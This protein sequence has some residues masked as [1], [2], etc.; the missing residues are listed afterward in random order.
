MARNRN[1]GGKNEGTGRAEPAHCIIRRQF[2]AAAIKH[3]DRVHDR[4]DTDAP[5]LARRHCRCSDRSDAQ[6]RYFGVVR[7]TDTF[8]LHTYAMPIAYRRSTGTHF[9]FNFYLKLDITAET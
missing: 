8:T 1:A 7:P 2:G 9:I 6:E 5:E 3:M 4:S